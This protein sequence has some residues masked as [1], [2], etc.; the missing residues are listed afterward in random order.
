[1][2]HE[3]EIRYA[4]TSDG[5]RIAYRTV[6][7]G[8]PVV[9][10]NPHAI[11]HLERE[12][13]IRPLR[14]WYE[15]LGEHVQVVR[16]SHRGFGLSE[17]DAS[18]ATRDDFVRDLEAVIDAL[19]AERV[20]FVAS[21]IGSP[22]AV[23]YAAR[24]PERVARLVL[25]APFLGYAGA[26]LGD[27][28]RRSLAVARLGMA[29]WARRVAA[30]VDPGGVVDEQAIQA[31]VT[32]SVSAET[33]ANWAEAIRRMDAADVVDAVRAPTLV[34]TR[35]EEIADSPPQTREP[36]AIAGVREIMLDGSAVVPY[37]EGGE[38]IFPLIRDF[39]LEA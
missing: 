25:F 28:V 19:G 11:T 27:A 16:M 29:V 21:G 38:K 31:L 34:L 33:H 4:L 24:Y 36:L 10:L 18:F 2:M 7:S 22:A 12:W 14:S 5:V 17:G 15:Q 32:E 30:W 23:A 39:L 8:L 3:T 9:V 1:M 20:G 37:F 13:E 35:R 6:G 26:E